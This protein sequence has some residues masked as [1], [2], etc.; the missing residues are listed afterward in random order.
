MST[1]KNLVYNIIG[2]ISAVIF[3]FVTVPYVSR[4]LG[5]DN[6]GI[7]GFASTYAQ[8]FALIAALGVPFYGS[9]EIAKHRDSPEQRNKLFS[10]LFMLTLISS[11]I[12]SIIY[13]ITVFSIPK[14]SEHLD[15]MVVAGA[16]VYLS[17]FSFDWFFA[18]RENF[19]MITIRS[20]S[21]KVMS[22][23]LM[24][25]FV[26]DKGD[27]IFYC[28]LSAF[29]IIANQLWNFNY[30]IRKEVKISFKNL[31]YRPHLKPLF[32]FL[33]TNLAVSVYTIL[34]TVMLGFMSNYSEV[35]YYTSAIRMTRVL[36]PFTILTTNVMVPKI[37]YAFSQNDTQTLNHYYRRSF[38]LISFF[39][40][41]IAVGLIVISPSF[42][43][44]F[45]GD[46]FAGAIV[47]MQILGTILL[48]VGVSN[49]FG[50]QVLA[51]SGNE[52]RLLHCILF[53]TV[54]NF[55]SNMVLIPTYGAVGAS[56]ASSIAEF[57]IV[58][59]TYMAAVKYLKIKVS[60]RPLVQSIISCLP[61]VAVFLLLPQMDYIQT[62]IIIVVS[63]VLSYSVMQY[64]V[65]R[66]EIARELLDKALKL[67][68]IKA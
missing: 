51:T 48:L 25:L 18:G 35:G 60:F 65:F 62:I 8:Y 68:K 10:E 64:F 9:K 57:I 6:I 45:F 55:L 49:F 24:F 54:V 36:L 7:V 20:V 28:G 44:L 42:V 43:P 59:T 2:N 33:A 17:A 56:I 4:V 29:A 58:F 22:I 30:L 52:S 26:R 11:F 31:N 3:P 13:L 66:S 53:G 16:A 61:M 47:P 34:D 37:S 21:V 27:A 40:A 14:L 1:K 46:G 19:K 41:P 23:I 32:T 63:A 12:C 67:L 5:V 15:F 50:I 39:A 38:S